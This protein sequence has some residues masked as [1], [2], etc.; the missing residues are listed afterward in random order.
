MHRLA[1]HV[2]IMDDWR[3]NSGTATRTTLIAVSWSVSWSVSDQDGSDQSVT[4]SA[5]VSTWLEKS[6]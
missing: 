2:E 3:E 4:N 6:T 1:L 5:T